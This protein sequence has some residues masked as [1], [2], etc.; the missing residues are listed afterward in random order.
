ME[1]AEIASDSAEAST[2]LAKSAMQVSEDHASENLT[3]DPAP[4]EQVEQEPVETAPM[5]AQ[6]DADAVVLEEP[7][8]QTEPAKEPAGETRPSPV[9]EPQTAPV[10]SG[11]FVPLV[12][13]GLVAGLCGWGAATYLLPAS[14]NSEAMAQQAQRIEAMESRIADFASNDTA[15]LE[16]R[17]AELDGAMAD[18]SA[19][20]DAMESGLT[21]QEPGAAPVDFSQDIA[22]LR[23]ML[24]RQEEELSDMMSAASE[25][26]TETRQEAESIQE[27][28]LAAANAAIARAAV[29]KV[30]AALESGAPF[31]DAVSELDEALSADVPDALRARADDGVTSLA[32]LQARFPDLARD[33]LAAARRA[34]VAGEESGAL[35]AFLRNQFNV[36]SVA[37][38]DGGS[39]DAVLS[40]AEAALRDG[41]LTDAVAEVQT[42]PSE[43]AEPL[44]GWLADAEARLAAI[45]AAASLSQQ[46]N[47]N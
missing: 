47:E 34:G 29:A 19:R 39:V 9:P 23:A 7:A 46:L 30:E 20:L 45:D 31:N 2:S 18:M 24:A 6:P 14:D 8:T 33:S 11:G 22:D 21:G 32:A 44:A 36:R 35:T 5:E 4:A 3:A 16:A 17:L 27:N 15:E 42:L 13:G 43:A 38:Q 37:P 25:A 26:L 1:N 12:L 40:R 41:R 10:R 28:T